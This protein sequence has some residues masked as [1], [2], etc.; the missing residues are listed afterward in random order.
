MENEHPVPE[1]HPALALSQR[2]SNRKGGAV[3]RHTMH[4]HTPNLT[5]RK[6]Y[7]HWCACTHITH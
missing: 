2:R 4:T 6:A 3:R 1:T 7:T 5:Q